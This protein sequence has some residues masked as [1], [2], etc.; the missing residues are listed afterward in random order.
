MK[1]RPLLLVVAALG[2]IALIVHFATRPSPAPAADPRVGQPFVSADLVERAARLR[3][4]EGDRTVDVVKADDGAWRVASYHDLPVDFAKLS[5]FI[6]DLTGAR[7][8][9]LVTRNPELIGR[10]EFKDTRIALAD[11]AG[12]ELWSVTLGK[13]ADGG[14]RFVRFGDEEAAFLTRFS[15]WLDTESSNWADTNLVGLKSEDIATVE[16]GF[17]NA[18]S[19]VA[20]RASASE[21][22]A[23][24]DAAGRAL[25]AATVTSLVST[26]TSLRFTDTVA[27]DDAD[28][29]D[30]KANAR[31]F[32]L[33]TFDGKTVTIALGRRP[34]STKPK[35]PDA[36]AGEAAKD[37]STSDATA[38][39]TET[40]PA[41]PV[42]AFVT[43][44]DAT[45]PV[46]AL[47]AKRAVKVAD[48]VF[49]GL[50]ASAEA[51]FD[52]PPA[53][54]KADDSL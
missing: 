4:S 10:L 36:T 52:A 41:G 7:L 26:L 42:F 15:A 32:T 16:I 21:P 48:Y 13:N 22:F 46:N 8:E 37:A 1:L 28:A 31:T 24:A 39:E 23:A 9:R 34:E 19:V 45:A 30:A 47:M 12:S 5:R 54:P 40:V 49:T 44:S 50:P 17:A 43:H 38:T 33:T 51:L 3:L 14:G 25:K 6:S 53:T 2:V 35:S 20:S 27:P 18:A 29:V 11:A